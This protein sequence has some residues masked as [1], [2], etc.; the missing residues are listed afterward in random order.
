M[1]T[2]ISKIR[3]A[4][5][6]K[7]LSVLV[8]K[9]CIQAAVDYWYLSPKLMKSRTTSA[10]DFKSLIGSVGW[11]EMW[12]ESELGWWYSLKLWQY[13]P[14]CVESFIDQTF[15][16]K[17]EALVW[18]FLG[19]HRWFVVKASRW[20]EK[21]YMHFARCCSRVDYEGCEQDYLVDLIA[22]LSREDR[23]WTMRHIIQ[24]AP[25]YGV[26]RNLGA[27]VF[28]YFVLDPLNK[29]NDMMCILLE[30]IIGSPLQYLLEYAIS[31]AIEE[32]QSMEGASPLVMDEAYKFGPKLL[33]K[34]LELY[35]LL[36][37]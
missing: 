9:H 20:E 25:E 17:R 16:N 19:A 35:T 11:L 4:F 8:Q 31:I 34:D 24:K 10:E 14:S 26:C 28:N 12:N 32:Y 29:V 27:N 2:K 33:R 6:T 5:T 23:I 13:G 18:L 36:E 1:L 3:E 30:E 21:E 37:M 15:K 22:S 7:N